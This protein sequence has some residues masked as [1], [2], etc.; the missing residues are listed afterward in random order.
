[1]TRNFFWLLSVGAA[2]CAGT[3]LQL[4]QATAETAKLQAGTLT[5]K[6]KGSVGLVLGSKETLVCKFSPVS[7]PE[8]SYNATVTNIGLDIGVKGASTMVW[9][10]LY[11]STNVPAGTLAGSYGGA[12]ADASIGIGG[13]ASVLVG[14][15]KKS[16]ALQ[17]LSVQGQTGLNLA[18]GVSGMTLKHVK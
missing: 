7:G 15:S 2:L 9:T 13:G 8:Q 12:S 18:V 17:P 3:A 10:V 6:G 11:S 5:C 14:G 4:R 16:I 1:M